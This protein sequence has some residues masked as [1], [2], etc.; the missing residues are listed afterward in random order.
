MELNATSTTVVP[1]QTFVR[2]TSRFRSL[3]ESKNLKDSISHDITSMPGNN[4]GSN[5]DIDI[6]NFNPFRAVLTDSFSE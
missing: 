4:S 3:N 2:S 6:S 5:K 1:M